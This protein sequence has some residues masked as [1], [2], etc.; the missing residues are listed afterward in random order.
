M[1]EVNLN[2]LTI[3]EIYMLLDIKLEE[4]F[5]AQTTVLQAYRDFTQRPQPGGMPIVLFQTVVQGFSDVVVFQR[6]LP[7]HSIEWG[8][9]TLLQKTAQAMNERVYLQ[10]VYDWITQ[11]KKR[12]VEFLTYI[13]GKGADDA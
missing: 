8:R 3:D 9:L 11:L 7:L 1:A 2:E 5:V 12:Q 4:V 6:D 10:A 13:G